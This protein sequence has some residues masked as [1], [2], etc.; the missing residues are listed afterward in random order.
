[1]HDDMMKCNNNKI[2]HT[3]A[4]KNME[5]VWSVGLGASQKI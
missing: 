5:G 4:T 2:K 1:M 3:T